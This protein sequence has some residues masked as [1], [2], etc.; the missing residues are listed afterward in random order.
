LNHKH[1]E[2]TSNKKNYL[3]NDS[4]VRQRNSSF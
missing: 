1:N 2:W 4:R 3:D